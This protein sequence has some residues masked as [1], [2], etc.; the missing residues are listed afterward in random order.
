[1]SKK[2]TTRE[3]AKHLAEFV[4]SQESCDI[5]VFTQKHTYLGS[6]SVRKQILERHAEAI[7][8]LN[9]P[10]AATTD[11]NKSVLHR[12]AG[13]DMPDVFYSVPAGDA[14][15]VSPDW[16][17]DRREIMAEC[18]KLRAERDELKRRLNTKSHQIN[19]AIGSREEAYISRDK[20]MD[21]TEALRKRLDESKKLAESLDLACAKLEQQLAAPKAEPDSED[22][23]E[24]YDQAVESLSVARSTIENHKQRISDLTRENEGRRE[25]QRLW[26]LRRDSKPDS[27]AI[28]KGREALAQWRYLAA[29]D[30]T[31]GDATCLLLTSYAETISAALDAAEAGER[32]IAELE[33]ELAKAAIELCPYFGDLKDIGLLNVAA[34]VRDVMNDRKKGLSQQ[35]PTEPNWI[36]KASDPASYGQPPTEQAGDMPL[37]GDCDNRAT[38]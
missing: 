9:E 37:C 30:R 34:A 32:R 35:P 12:I 29:A 1:M 5:L 22:Q 17:D 15:P 19:A 21:E 8:E 27:E 25:V 24:D 28:R 10:E 3:L 11:T 20:A 13:G 38:C 7:A 16:K 18:E 36:D 33:A 23:P 26:T 6:K 14:T 4:E 2:L 31:N